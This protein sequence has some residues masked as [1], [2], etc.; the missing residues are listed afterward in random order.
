[1]IPFFIL[2]CFVFFTIWGKSG[3][4]V[5]IILWFDLRTVFL[6]AFLERRIYTWYLTVKYAS[7]INEIFLCKSFEKLYYFYIIFFSYK[8]F[9]LSVC[10]GMTWDKDGDTLAIGNEKTGDF[11]RFVFINLKL[12]FLTLWNSIF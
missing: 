10:T 7:N 12:L 1:M 6:R 4:V 3:Y 2:Y 9:S 8:L 11:F 5:T